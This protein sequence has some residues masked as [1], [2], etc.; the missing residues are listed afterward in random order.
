[1]EH[2][3]RHEENMSSDDE[4]RARERE[5]LIRS[6]LTVA[7]RRGRRI[8]DLTAKRIAQQLDPGSGS[9]HEFAET[10]AIADSID[11]DLTAAGEV[12]RDLEQEPHLPR[13]TALGEYFAGRIIKSELPYWNDPGME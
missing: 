3:P 6:G 7:W 11:A 10:G 8:D 2:E 1:M 12:V 4:A 13:L 9:L 5:Q